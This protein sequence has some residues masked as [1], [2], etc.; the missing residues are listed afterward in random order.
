MA[1]GGWSSAWYPKH[2][3]VVYKETKLLSLLRKAKL[4]EEEITSLVSVLMDR[5]M[6]CGGWWGIT[7]A[8]LLPL[9][10]RKLAE[11]KRTKVEDR[12][13]IRALKQEK[14]PDIDIVLFGFSKIS[15]GIFKNIPFYPSK[16]EQ[17]VDVKQLIKKIPITTIK[18][19][20]NATMKY[21][22][23]EQWVLKWI[24]KYRNTIYHQVFDRK[25]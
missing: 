25:K 20:S 11:R 5:G 21:G 22:D 18:N 15:D 16:N 6:Q 17:S 19:V 2:K 4:S 10:G 7:R 12:V 3:K 9:W 1:F 24:K 13:W 8:R 23:T 14:I